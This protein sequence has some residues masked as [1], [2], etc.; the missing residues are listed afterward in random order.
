MNNFIKLHV[1]RYRLYLL[2]LGFSL[3]EY[4]IMVHAGIWDKKLNKSIIKGAHVFLREYG[5]FGAI[6]L[7]VLLCGLI[8]VLGYFIFKIRIASRSYWALTLISLI[9]MPIIFLE[10][11]SKVHLNSLISLGTVICFIWVSYTVIVGTIWLY[12][13][14]VKDS[15]TM[16]AKLTFI[17]SVLAALL[18]YSIGRSK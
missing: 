7:I 3:I 12:D 17:W 14:I 1:E 15:Q 5:K 13:W 9:V 8:I 18:G 4:S 6:P 16:L 11:L 10:W 2:A